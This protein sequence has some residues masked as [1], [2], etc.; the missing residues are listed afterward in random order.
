MDYTH[1]SDIQFDLPHLHRP[2][3]AVLTTFCL[4]WVSVF[5][6]DMSAKPGRNFFRH[7]CLVLA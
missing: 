4:F 5:I 1:F 2:T 7:F 3:A 6:A